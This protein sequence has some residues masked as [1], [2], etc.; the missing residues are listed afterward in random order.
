VQVHPEDFGD[1]WP[2]TVS[3]FAVISCDSTGTLGGVG[4]VYITVGG[5]LYALNGTAKNSGKYPDI[6]PI[7]ANDSSLPGTKKS[8]GVLI[9]KGLELC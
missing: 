6:K 2:L 9:D 5:T 3:D 8:I 7:W 4:G 1:K